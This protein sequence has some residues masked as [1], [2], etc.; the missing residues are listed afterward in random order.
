MAESFFSTLQAGLHSALGL[1]VTHHLR[2]QHANRR[3][4]DLGNKPTNRPRDRADSNP[5]LDP[6]TLRP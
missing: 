2:R 1:P 5:T 4:R 6:S 3:S